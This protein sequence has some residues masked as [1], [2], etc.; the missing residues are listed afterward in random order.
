MTL[1]HGRAVWTLAALA[2]AIFGAGC[3]GGPG[4]EDA[5]PPDLCNS[6]DEALNDSRC[7]LQ[8][9]ADHLDFISIPNDQD[10]FSFRTPPTMNA[11]SLLRV[12]GGYGV[13]ATPVQLSLNVLQEDGRASISGLVADKHGQGAP[14]GLQILTRFTAPDTRLVLLAAD[15]PDSP[16]RPQSDARNPYL[17]R[18]TV[19][20]DPDP[21]EP[22]D[23]TATPIP[24]DASFSGSQTGVL[25][26]QDDR[27]LFSINAPTVGRILYFHIG[28]AT[29]SPKPAL[30]RLAYTLYSPGGTQ[31][32]EG[33]VDNVFSTVDLATA[34]IVQ[35]AGTYTLDVHAYREPGVIGPLPGDDRL[36]YKIDVLIVD[37]QDANEPN[38]NIAQADPRAVSLALGS[39]RTFTGRIGSVG[40]PDWFAVDVPSS[41]NAQLLHYKV[42]PP[43]GTGRFPPLPLGPG[44]I[45]DREVSVV[46]VVTQGTAAC[47]TDST[48]C[49]KGYGGN[50]NYQLAVEQICA[51]APAQCLWSTREEDYAYPNLKNFE[52]KFPI[53][54][55]GTTTRYYV[56]VQDVGNDWADDRNYTLQVTLEADADDTGRLSQPAQTEVVPLAQDTSGATFPAPPAGASTLSGKLSF[57]Y[58]RLFNNDPAVGQGI[59]GPIDYDAVET[60][61]DRYELDIPFQDPA[62]GP[63]DRT[64]ELQWT[65]QN[66]N[67]TQPENLFVDVE[68]CDGTTAPTDGGT[69]SSV[70][71]SRSG[72]GLVFT[73]DDASLY[74]WWNINQG[75]GLQ[76]LWD[77]ATTPTS[78]TVTARGYGCFCFEPRFIQGGKFFLRVGGVD[79]NTWDETTYTVKTAFTAYP[80]SF[81]TQADGGTRSCP[82]AVPV[83]AGTPDGGMDGG[84][85]GG[86]MDAGSG[87]TGGCDFTR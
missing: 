75:I 72:G 19:L 23:A 11:R 38:D 56:V 60:D 22:N 54:P 83:D 37:Q 34:R 16:T 9:D 79:R 27:D 53:S 58:G 30:Y 80:K 42:T 40:D 71:T 18:W 13:P 8:Q 25:A 50:P 65:V 24:L 33:R 32:A 52:G 20:Q 78:S 4:G 29:P 47:Q 26:T 31:V 76:P 77:L 85:D 7:A 86:T 68:L 70:K 3:P 15:L 84:T 62:N 67:G 45:P 12:T 61:L 28:E 55:H 10:W 43:S 21:N 73:Y 57:G 64:W 82:A 46:T 66:V 41:A 1:R 81:V 59:R 51:R 49:P 48:L 74:S 69:C 39:T 14:Q 44:G 17:V 2:V 87:F 36:T 35:A 5:L 63:L 6:L